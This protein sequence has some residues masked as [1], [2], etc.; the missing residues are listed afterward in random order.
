MQW[1]NVNF[2]HHF[3]V[4]SIENLL[5]IVNCLINIENT[6]TISLVMQWHLLSYLDHN[7]QLTAQKSRFQKKKKK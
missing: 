3:T 1:N 4:K 6:H 5:F 2:Q 7:N